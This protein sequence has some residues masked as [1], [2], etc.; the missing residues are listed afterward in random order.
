ML[1]CNPFQ[2]CKGTPSPLR[3]SNMQQTI[4]PSEKIFKNLQKGKT[5]LLPKK[6]TPMNY[7]EE[8][9]FQPGKISKKWL[10]PFSINIFRYNG[11]NSSFLFTNYLGQQNIDIASNIYRFQFQ[12]PILL[13]IAGETNPFGDIVGSYTRPWNSLLEMIGVS[14]FHMSGENVPKLKGRNIS[15]QKR[16]FIEYL[17]NFELRRAWKFRKESE[18]NSTVKRN[19]FS[20]TLRVKTKEI[21]TKRRRSNSIYEERRNYWKNFLIFYELLGI[22]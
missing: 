20:K 4:F 14:R 22:L 8:N 6:I 11:E 19:S 15:H 9:Y 21:Q 12:M 1:K 5:L 16:I 17:G 13:F 3:L 18:K 7:P 2:F 10:P